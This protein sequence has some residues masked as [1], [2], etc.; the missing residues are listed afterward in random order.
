MIDETLLDAEEK[1]EKAVSVAKE[2]FGGIRTGRATPAT[3]CPVVFSSSFSARETSSSP[4]SPSLTS[5]SSSSLALRLM[6][7][8]DT[9]ASSALPRATL[10]NSRRRS[11]VSC[12]N[13][14]RMTAPSLVGLTPRSESRIARSIAPIELLSYGVTTTMRGSGTAREASWMTGVMAP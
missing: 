2:D 3:Y 7:R 1:M 13:T 5:R 6:L 4:V 14:M 8:M 12:G 10:M 9:L 11:S